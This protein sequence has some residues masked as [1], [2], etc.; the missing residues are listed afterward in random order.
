MTESLFK[1]PGPKSGNCCNLN[2]LNDWLIN[3]CSCYE[4]TGASSWSTRLIKVMI[5]TYVERG[6]T[7]WE[8]LTAVPCL[9]VYVFFFFFYQ[10]CASFTCSTAAQSTLVFVWWLGPQ[11]QDGHRQAQAWWTGNEI[12]HHVCQI[13]E[14]QSS[15]KNYSEK[16]TVQGL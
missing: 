16:W 4:P 14:V 6:Q 12:M 9:M 15:L 11:Q 7:H 2:E 1:D 10:A 3:G 13:T 8:L 5:I